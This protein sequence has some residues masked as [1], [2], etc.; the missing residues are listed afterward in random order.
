M[1]KPS[2]LDFLRSQFTKLPPVHHV[3]LTGQTVVVTGSNVGL[4]LEAAKYFARMNPA[5]LILAVRSKS[6]RKVMQHSQVRSFTLYAGR[7]ANL[8]RV[9]IQHETGYEGG[10]V[11][12]LD[13]GDFASVSAFAATFEKEHDRLDI[14]VCNA[15]V[16]T[17]DYETSKDG[18][19]TTYVSNLL[20]V[21]RHLDLCLQYS[22]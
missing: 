20:S 18:W 17:F 15:G 14:L 1:A 5:N 19:E 9:E 11:M 6:N 21:P 8:S 2:A 4:G 7:W 13:L 12:I 3:D 10:K 22:S 16:E